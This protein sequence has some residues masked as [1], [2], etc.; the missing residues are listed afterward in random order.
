LPQ[1]IVDACPELA[2]TTL[3]T[4]C[5]SEEIDGGSRA[6][7]LYIKVNC[8]NASSSADVFRQLVLTATGENLATASVHLTITNMGYLPIVIE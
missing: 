3:T 8:A 7:G 1:P 4:T 6:N 2:G 5:G